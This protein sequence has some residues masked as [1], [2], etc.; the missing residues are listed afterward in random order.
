MTVGCNLLVGCVIDVLPIGRKLL[1]GLVNDIFTGIPNLIYDAYLHERLRKY[2]M[3]GVGKSVQVISTSNQYVLYSASL[4]ISQVPH[5]ERH[6]KGSFQAV[7]FQIDTEIDSLVD[8]PSI[9]ANLEYNTVHT[10]DEI[11]GIQKLVLPFLSGLIDLV[12]NDG[13]G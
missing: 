13:D 1:L 10:N 6:A 5:P 4:Q 11:D 9:V 2:G 7:L 12:R 3:Y 8:D